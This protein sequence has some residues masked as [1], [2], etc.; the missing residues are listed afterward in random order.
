MEN[1]FQLKEVFPLIGVI[2]LIII[3]HIML[4]SDWD[5]LNLLAATT[6]TILVFFTGCLH[7]VRTDALTQMYIAFFNVEVYAK[8]KGERFDPEIAGRKLR[9]ANYW[10]HLYKKNS[11]AVGYCLCSIIV[12]SC[13]FLFS[14]S[15]SE[16][17]LPVFKISIFLSLFF[18]AGAL[19]ILISKHKEFPL[20]EIVVSV[21]SGLNILKLSLRDER[22]KELEEKICEGPQKGN[23]N[24]PKWFDNNKCESQAKV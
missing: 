10:G 16:I 24:C 3:L 23:C 4:P 20:S 2:I 12:M 8:E 17:L 18:L 6:L 11:L 1:E 9:H 14:L 5:D 15:K 7:P 21:W 13:A 22:V 19:R